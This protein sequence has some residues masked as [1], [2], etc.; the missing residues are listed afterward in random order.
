M[1]FIKVGTFVINTTYI[2]AVN[3][4]NQTLSG[5]VNVSILVAV[6]KFFLFESEA[7]SQNIYHYEWIKF[8]GKEAQVLQ[9]YFSSF[10]NVVDLLP[11]YQEI[12]AT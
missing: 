1:A 3:L 12:A 8:T 5:E 4:E 6:P 10:N 7:I 11:D 9:D 2:A